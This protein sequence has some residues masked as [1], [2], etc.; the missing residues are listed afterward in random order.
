MTK[1]PAISHNGKQELYLKDIKYMMS[2]LNHF[3]KAN[4][5]I[6]EER[7]LTQIL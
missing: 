2:S 4:V 1:I 3:T 7:G 6:E 5:I